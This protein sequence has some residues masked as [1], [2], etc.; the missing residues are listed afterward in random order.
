[1]L[2]GES[3]VP[4][5]AQKGNF[6]KDRT[7]YWHFPIYLQN[8]AGE[9]DQSRDLKFRTRP[10]TVLRSGKWKLHEYF[11]DGALLLFDLKKDPGEKNDISG[12]KPKKLQKLKKDMYAW[13]KRTNS[14]V[15]TKRNPQY[16]PQ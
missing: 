10:G 5:L 8:Y 3:I 2:D 9:E 7:L 1:V 16:I 12:A 13:R 4:L 6:P 14:P 11:E 15:P